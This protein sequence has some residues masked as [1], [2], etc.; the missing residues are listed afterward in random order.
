MHDRG[1]WPKGNTV[2]GLINFSFSLIIL[3]LLSRNHLSGLNE[4]A[5]VYVAFLRISAVI[6]DIGSVNK[7]AASNLSFSCTLAFLAR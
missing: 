2:Y 5:L 7:A 1:P 3:S 6:G 4:F